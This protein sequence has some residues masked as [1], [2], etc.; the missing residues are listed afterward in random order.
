MGHDPTP[1][2]NQSDSCHFLLDKQNELIIESILQVN[3]EN[4]EV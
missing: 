1:C 2:M 3:F 4:K